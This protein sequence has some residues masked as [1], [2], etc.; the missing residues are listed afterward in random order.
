MRYF[1]KL[2]ESIPLLVKDFDELFKTFTKSFDKF[3][4]F[5]KKAVILLV[6]LI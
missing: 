3:E 4:I 6:I 1:E 5:L 2:E